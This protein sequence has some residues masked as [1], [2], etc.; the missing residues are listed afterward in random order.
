MASDLDQI[1]YQYGVF[2]DEILSHGSELFSNYNEKQQRLDEF[3]ITHMKDVKYEEVIAVIRM[4]LVLSHGQATVERGFFINKE[5]ECENLQGQSIIAQ[6]LICDKVRS[7]GGVLK[8]IITPQLLVSCANA[9]MK[10]ETNLEKQRQETLTQ[11]S[12]EKE[13]QHWKG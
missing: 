3:F 2:L 10:Y 1:I 4:L 5:L 7:C 12:K 9:R 13:K 6:G 8:V 11:E